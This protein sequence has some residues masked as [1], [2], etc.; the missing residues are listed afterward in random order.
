[1]ECRVDGVFVGT[2]D[3]LDSTE[4]VGALGVV[5]DADCLLLSSGSGPANLSAHHSYCCWQHGRACTV[6]ATKLFPP[7]IWLVADWYY[8]QRCQLISHLDRA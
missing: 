3:G 2:G 8:R 4:I 5:V 7:K 1:M 6:S